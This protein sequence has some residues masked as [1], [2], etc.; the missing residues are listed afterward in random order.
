LIRTRQN[1]DR[2]RPGR[3]FD[4][5]GEER[6]IGEIDEGARF[7]TG[8]YIVVQIPENPRAR[9][10]FG[11]FGLRVAVSQ[12]V[13]AGRSVLAMLALAALLL[14]LDPT[15][16]ELESRRGLPS[17]QTPVIMPPSVGITGSV[18]KGSATRIRSQSDNR[19]SEGPSFR[20]PV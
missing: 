16:S 19:R 12:T 15:P 13:I 4:R 10:A 20:K 1:R 8:D 6:G 5:S 14:F 18:R 17:G 2:A 3:P 7:A 11:E 9:L